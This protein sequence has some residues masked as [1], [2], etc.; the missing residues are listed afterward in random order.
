MIVFL[1]SWKLNSKTLETISECCPNLEKVVLKCCKNLDILDN[2]LENCQNITS[3][4]VA[5][6]EKIS[7]ENLMKIPE[8]LLKLNTF[9]LDVHRRNLLENMKNIYPQL[10][11]L[12]CLSEFSKT[13]EKLQ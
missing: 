11:I 2:F 4:N 6:C 8:K 13:M 5:F 1:G 10:N 3:L 7:D 9:Y 12:V